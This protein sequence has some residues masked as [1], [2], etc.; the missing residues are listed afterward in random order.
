LVVEKERSTGFAQVVYLMVEKV[1]TR[2]VWEYSR[3]E[4]NEMRQENTAYSNTKTTLLLEEI[5]SA[6]LEDW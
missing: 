1:Q 3:I 5:I 2:R 6:F 4:G